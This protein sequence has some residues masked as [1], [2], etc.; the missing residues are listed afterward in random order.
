MRGV[1]ELDPGPPP[2]TP[3]QRRRVRILFVRFTTHGV[4]NRRVFEVHLDA[5]R[6]AVEGINDGWPAWTDDD[7]EKW[8][9]YIDD[10]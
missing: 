4:D 8:G 2:L 5:L 10:L 7:L 1:S 6:K 9:R 3:S